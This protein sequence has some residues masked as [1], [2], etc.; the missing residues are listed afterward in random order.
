[1]YYFGIKLLVLALEIGGHLV[2]IIMVDSRSAIDLLYLPTM[3]KMGYQTL[4]LHN[5]GRVL[6]SFKGSMII[7]PGE[8]AFTVLT[9]LVTMFMTFPV[10]DNPS[11][12]NT[13][14]SR[15]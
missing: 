10:V 7:L 15:T 14:P 4:N 6:M 5:T 1:M 11:S 9:S 3:I 8:I 2:C 13:I 12:F